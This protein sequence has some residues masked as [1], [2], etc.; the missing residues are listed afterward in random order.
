MY[1][2]PFPFTHFPTDVSSRTCPLVNT[3]R[4]MR[5]GL[6]GTRPPCEC[7]TGGLREAL[8]QSGRGRTDSENGL[9]RHLVFSETEQY[10]LVT[11]LPQPQTLRAVIILGQF[12]VTRK[13]CRITVI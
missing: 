12:M 7:E 8:E 4:G 3:P 5:R 6:G 11:G 9:G 10:D 13:V 2:Q 1:F